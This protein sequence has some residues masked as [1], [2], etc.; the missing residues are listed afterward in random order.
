[1]L[2]QP[3]IHEALRV[4]RK[5][6]KLFYHNA[7]LGTDDSLYN[8]E[9][10]KVFRIETLPGILE[11]LKDIESEKDKLTALTALLFFGIGNKMIWKT[12]PYVVPDRTNLKGMLRVFKK[13]G[14]NF[15]KLGEYVETR[16]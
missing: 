10:R 9:S 16:R 1:M 7:A 14:T 6:D 2:K 4:I 8:S 5:M 15:S 11:E 13:V 12:E 3:R